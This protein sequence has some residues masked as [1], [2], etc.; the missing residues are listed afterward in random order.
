MKLLS[1]FGV[2]FIALMAVAFVSCDRVPYNKGPVNDAVEL[3]L[4]Q[5]GPVKDDLVARG[6]VTIPSGNVAAT[7]Q[8]G[9]IKIPEIEI[10]VQNG[11][12]AIDKQGYL[13]FGSNYTSP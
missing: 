11:V 8:V 1:I 13:V 10:L 7:P 2:A 12:Y 3:T 5:G 4:G 9:S 6:L